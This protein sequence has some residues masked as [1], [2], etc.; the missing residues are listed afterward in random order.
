MNDLYFKILKE[1]IRHGLFTTTNISYVFKDRFLYPD[2]ERGD[3]FGYNGRLDKI[4]ELLSEMQNNKHIVFKCYSKRIYETPREQS[5]WVKPINI[6]AKITALGYV[7]YRDHRQSARNNIFSRVA[8]GISFL[9]ATF[10]GW[11]IF[12][13]QNVD[14][15][16]K[17]QSS[18][19]V[20]KESLQIRKKT[21]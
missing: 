16:Q 17:A 7:F 5:K 15:T 9:S 21:K 3:L 19:I 11:P 14:K 2:I 1:L 8:L 13:K 20:K 6:D 18:E 4:I 10:T 12:T